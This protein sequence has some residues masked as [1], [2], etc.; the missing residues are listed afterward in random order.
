MGGISLGIA[1]GPD[2]AEGVAGWKKSRAGL[3][4]GTSQASSFKAVLL[5]PSWTSSTLSS[6]TRMLVTRP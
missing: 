3:V 2:S 5:S 6:S 1:W 4:V